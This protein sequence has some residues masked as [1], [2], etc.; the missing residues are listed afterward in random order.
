VV[1]LLADGPV[2]YEAL[3]PRVLELPLVWNSDLNRILVDGDRSGRFVIEGRGPRQRIPK[4]GCTIR[5]AT[6]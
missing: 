4:P 1:T 6:A 3:Q 2:P 5:L